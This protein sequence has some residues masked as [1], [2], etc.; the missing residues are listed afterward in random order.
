L[1]TFFQELACPNQTLQSIAGGRRVA[2]CCPGWTGWRRVRW[3]QRKL[4]EILQALPGADNALM[5]LEH[6]SDDELRAAGDSH[7]EIRQ[8]AVDEQSEPAP[9]GG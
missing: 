6:A 5:A 7:R 3:P 2:G 8:A 1:S 4:D 9:P